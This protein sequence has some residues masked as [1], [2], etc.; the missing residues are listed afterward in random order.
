MKY[1]LILILLVI[2]SCSSLKNA[3]TRSYS[4]YRVNIE[5]LAGKEKVNLNGLAFVSPDSNFISIY[6][7][8]GISIA[9]IQTLGE[10][11][12]LVDMHNKK[13]FKTQYHNISSGLY[14][15][16][17]GK[18][19]SSENILLCRILNLVGEN[20]NIALNC[21]QQDGLKYQFKE[22]KKRKTVNFSLVGLDSHYKVKIDFS[23]TEKSNF[24]NLTK[25]ENF[26]TISISL[27]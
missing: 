26:E 10:S 19:S 25:Y 15:I 14:N 1:F 3:G 17:S 18:Y 2:F 5:V 21:N 27:Q 8:L 20:L 9:K 12:T 23:G 16:F 24:G 13:L 6:G 4:N 11:F 22:G 7:P